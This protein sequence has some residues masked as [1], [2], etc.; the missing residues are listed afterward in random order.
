MFQIRNID[1]VFRPLVPG[2]IRA[3]RA[4]EPISSVQE[5]ADA[6]LL[7]ASQRS[8]AAIQARVVQNYQRDQGL[9]EKKELRHARELMSSP[10]FSIL[11]SMLMSAVGQLF[12]QKRYRHLPV[13]RESGLLVGLISDRM[14]LRFAADPD[15]PKAER[16]TVEEVM[17]HE[18]LTATLDTLI[19]EVARTLFEERIGSLPI[20]DH[21]HQLVGMLTRSD[22]LRALITHG[23]LQIWA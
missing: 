21:S 1:G 4:I 9:P 8:R 5:I 15:S 12:A 3:R 6:T 14:A 11:P 22:I 2:E 13:C 16:T 10:V 18:V 7:S 19:R 20:I 23:P 17:V